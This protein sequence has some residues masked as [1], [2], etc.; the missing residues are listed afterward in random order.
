[1][2]HEH[3]CALTIAGDVYCW[4][5]NDRGQIG[6]LSAPPTTCPS[7]A[8]QPIPTRVEGVTNA[9][10]LAV[11][12]G[13]SCALL[14]DH[15]VRCWGEVSALGSWPALTSVQSITLGAAGAC[16]L[17]LAGALRCSGEGGASVV[18]PADVSG[19]AAVRLSS[20]TAVDHS[21]A[22]FLGQDGGLGCSGD[23][24]V[25]QLGLGSLVATST[26]RRVLEHTKDIALG[27]EHAC[28]LGDDR[29]VRCW[30]KNSEGQVGPA[31]LASPSCG[32]ATCE[33]VPQVVAGLPPI[34][35]IAAGG[36]LS[37]ALAQ[38]DTFWCWGADPLSLG[39]PFRVAGPWETNGK[40][41]GPVVGEIATSIYEAA[42]SD[43]SCSTDSDCL[44]VSLDV[45]CSKSCAV[46]SLSRSSA[47]A[48]SRAIARI[49]SDVCPRARELGCA[50]PTVTCPAPATG[51]ACN[52]GQCTH[53][54][55]D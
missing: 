19:L 51:V 4:G 48:A 10:Q 20:N 3:S 53:R 47:D 24:S 32:L 16:A 49:D 23:A 33:T 30:G 45:S 44:D 22:C 40:L 13:R 54:R 2:S 28:A 8:C 42:S 55:R 25:G 14:A 29:K 26:G 41:C 38:D 27:A 43:R 5:S 6:K 7:G 12:S 36:N 18:Q 17:T 35:A 34:T 37:C 1:V 31:P 9:V 52:A 46:A 39:A 11:S 21:F 15:T 50:Q